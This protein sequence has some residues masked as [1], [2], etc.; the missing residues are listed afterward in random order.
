MIARFR[1]ATRAT[2]TRREVF[3]HVYDDREELARAHAKTRHREYKPEDD[4]AGG[5]STMTMGYHWPH[6]DGE[7]WQIMRL[8]TEQLTTRTI[9]HE[10]THA[11]A[12]LVMYDSMPGWNARLRTFLNGD[13][14]PMAYAVGDITADVIAALYR[15]KILPN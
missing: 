8:W 7:V 6:P 11:A 5:V 9:A 2:G 13:N 1:V 14:E 4:V 3:V 10:A 15:L 12:C